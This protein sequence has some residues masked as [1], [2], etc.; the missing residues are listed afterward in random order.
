MSKL[1]PWFCSQLVALWPTC[2]PYPIPNP[3]PGHAGGYSFLPDHTD[4]SLQ[5]QW[6]HA[7]LWP[8]DS[9][10]RSDQKNNL[11]S[12]GVETLVMTK[13]VTHFKFVG[14]YFWHSAKT[15][16]YKVLHLSH[17][18][19]HSPLKQWG[20]DGPAGSKIWEGKLRGIIMEC[21]VV[22][23]CCLGVLYRMA[24]KKIL[25]WGKGFKTAWI[26]DGS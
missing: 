21:K 25:E 1:E 7:Y 12:P 26:A 11:W 14:C 5:L 22:N 3:S 8:V 9:W 13:F 18:T 20:A 10:V 19:L 17:K 23:N 16:L 6:W 24:K 2:V 15:K 4:R